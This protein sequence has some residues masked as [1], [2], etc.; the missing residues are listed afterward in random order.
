LSYSA[1]PFPLVVCEIGSHLAGLYYDPPIR[2]SCIIGHDRCMT[3]PAIS[4]HGI[5]QTLPKMALNHSLLISTS[6][7]ARIIGLCHCTW[8]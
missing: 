2:A 3:H 4:S 7:V 8:P 6:Q 5:L 1:S